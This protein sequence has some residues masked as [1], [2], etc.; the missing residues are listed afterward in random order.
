MSHNRKTNRDHAKKS[1]RPMVEDKVIGTQLEALVTPA[2]TAQENYYRRLG[3]RERILN[4][5]LMV[6]ALLTLSRARCVGSQGI[7]A[8]PGVMRYNKNRLKKYS[9]ESIFSR[10]ANKNSSSTSRAEAVDPKNSR[11][12][13]RK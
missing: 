7:T 10:F 4:L 8:L 13:C 9:N 6:A 11:N 3:L 1:Q 5:P 2:I 12:I